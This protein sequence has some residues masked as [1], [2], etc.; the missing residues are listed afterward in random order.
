MKKNP[1][2]FKYVGPPSNLVA[3]IGADN[4]RFRKKEGFFISQGEK[5]VIKA[6]PRVLDLFEPI[7]E[8]SKQN[9]GIT[10]S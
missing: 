8:S 5:I 10:A 3:S 1:R 4:N 2:Y 9:Y 6:L 7:L